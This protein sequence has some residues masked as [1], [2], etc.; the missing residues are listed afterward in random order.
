MCNSEANCL[1]FNMQSEHI[2]NRRFHSLGRYF[3][4]EPQRGQIIDYFFKPQFG[5]SLDILKV[6]VG[7]DGQNTLGVRLPRLAVRCT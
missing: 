6:E 2:I 3:Y 4:D 7:G 5:A 1:A